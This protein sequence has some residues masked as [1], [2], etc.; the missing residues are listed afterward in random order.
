MSKRLLFAAGSLATAVV[1]FGAGPSSEA[2]AIAKPT[3]ATV[4]WPGGHCPDAVTIV[5][6]GSGEAPQSPGLEGYPKDNYGMG[7]PGGWTA[8]RVRSIGSNRGIN[9]GMEG[10]VY[11]ASPIEDLKHNRERYVNSIRSGA[12]SVVRQV[13]VRMERGCARTPA[14]SLVGYSQGAWAI[15]IALLR[16]A[17]DGEDAALAQIRSVV[18]YGDPAY[19]SREKIV[20]WNRPSA[21]R[22]GVGHAAAMLKVVPN[23]WLDPLP[24]AVRP[25]ATSL[26]LTRDVVCRPQPYVLGWGALHFFQW[27]VDLKVGTEIHTTYVRTEAVKAGAKWIGDR[28]PTPSPDDPDGGQPDGGDPVGWE[29]V[30][31]STSY[32]QS[33]CGVKTDSSAWCWGYNFSGEL[34]DGT[35]SSSPVPVRVA[36]GSTWKSVDPGSGHSCG[37]R[38]NGTAWCWGGT[39]QSGQ[40]GDGT[41]NSSLAPVQVAGE[42]TWQTVKAGQSYSCGVK[43]DGSAWCWGS[44]QSGLLGTGRG[45]LYSEVP[46]QVAGGGTWRSIDTGD[47]HACGVKQDGTAWCW[48]SSGYGQLGVGH[49]AGNSYAPVQVVGGGAW[50]TLVV[51]SVQSCGVKTDG[52]GWCWGYNEDGRLGD[53]TTTSSQVPVQVAGGGSWRAVETTGASTPG[54][55]LN[56]HS[57]G[58]KSDSTMW[59]WGDNEFG[60]LGTGTNQSSLVPQQ[61]EGGSAW[62]ATAVTYVH[63]CGVRNDG[64]AWCWGNNHYGLGDGTST[65]SSVPVRVI[66]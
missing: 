53:G 65:S 14:L 36:G 39:N 48:G 61:V 12:D 31:G 29:A 50:Q 15:R 6:R 59:C 62:R 63:S 18:L 33:T 64:T 19:D 17:R 27:L 32:A 47:G 56:G 60:Q 46:V 10:I 2:E 40:L 24:I 21:R 44:N 41:T 35:T 25:R 9:A 42:G 7:E 30:S 11:P 1:T 3:L 43:S 34:G 26:C 54:F 13:R 20:R 58:V 8:R 22:H 57:C 38:I 28:L 55:V 49:T 23:W 66:D 45:F 51:G 37:V 4:V 52:T 5:A 16:L